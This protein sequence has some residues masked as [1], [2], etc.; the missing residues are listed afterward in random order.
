MPSM[1]YNQTAVS[2]ERLLK[3]VRLLINGCS[4]RAGKLEG[5]L[6]GRKFGT[7]QFHEVCSCCILPM[8][9]LHARQATVPGPSSSSQRWPP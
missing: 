4:A 6:L 3:T 5:V 7:P 9:K 1:I 2:A 8:F